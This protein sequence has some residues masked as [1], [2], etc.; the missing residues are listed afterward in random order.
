MS[1]AMSGPLQAAIFDALSADSALAALVGSAI[2]DAVP[3]GSLPPIYV[4]LGGEA[5][6][7][8]SDASGAGA[9]HVVTVSVI[10]TQPGFAG[11]KA[12]AAAISDA[13]HAADLPLSRGRLVWLQF[14]K[15]T[16]ARIDTA[17]ARQI[18]LQFRARVQDD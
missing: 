17:S 6:Q 11:A 7:D 8:A 1:Y 15:A 5:A 9:L 14:H 16:A 2:Y 18:D 3:G 12:A 10:T 4:R 13:L